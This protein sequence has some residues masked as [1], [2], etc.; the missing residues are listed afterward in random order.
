MPKRRQNE[1]SDE[2]NLTNREEAFVEEM[3]NPETKSGAEAARKAG[4]S[5]K[6]ARQAA[7]ENLT[8]PHILKAIAKRR[9]ELAQISQVKADEIFVSAAAEM[10]STIDDV[11][12]K[13][14]RFDIKK[15]RRTG[16]IHHVRKLSFKE[17]KFGTSVSFEMASAADARRE[18]SDYLGLKQLPRENERKLQATVNAIRQYLADH[19][20]ADREVVIRTFASGRGVET[21]HVIEELEKIQ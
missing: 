3:V 21:D 13:N 17:T 14:G 1:N 20:E 6:T 9:A 7:S 4:Y 16:A 12:D 11:L 8:K 19:P 2:I 10:Y 15:A 5:P 18:I